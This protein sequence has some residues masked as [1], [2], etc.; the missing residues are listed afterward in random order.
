MEGAL[1]ELP[2]IKFY[3][4]DWIGD[5]QLRL[6]PLAARG[7]WIDMI[8]LM[9]ASQRRGF[10]EIGGRPIKDAVTLS[11]VIGADSNEV[12]KLLPEMEQAGVFSRDENGVIYSRRMV[13]DTALSEQ[14]RQAGLRG[15]NPS[16]V[17]PVVKQPLKQED[18]RLV[19]PV[20]KPRVHKPE[21]RVQS[22]K[23]ISHEPLT[24]QGSGL[25][26][27]GFLAGQMPSGEVEFIGLLLELCG[28]DEGEQWNGRWRNDWRDNRPKL[29]RALADLRGAI[30]DGKP[31]GSIGGYLRDV[32]DKRMAP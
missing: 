25:S 28:K 26:R 19:K 21:S 23:T 5:A 9:A 8:C 29:L 17:K 20:V 24:A 12:A 31:I 1:M 14:K 30:K 22:P 18:N 10:L 3:T 7:L 2:F 4:S 15:G 32:F 11:R 13:R 27:K 6:L 16:L